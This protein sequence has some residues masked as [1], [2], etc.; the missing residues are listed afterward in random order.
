MI[1][2]IT[3]S[4]MLKLKSWYLQKGTCVTK[5]K[6]FKLMGPWMQKRLIW[7][8]G[9]KVGQSDLLSMQLKFEM[10]QHLLNVYTY[11][12]I[13]VSEYVEKSPE[14]LGPTTIFQTGVSKRGQFASHWYF[15]SLKM[16]PMPFVVGHTQ[17]YPSRYT[18]FP[19]ITTII[20]IKMH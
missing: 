17:W 12:H 2:K 11:F 7:P 6:K 19:H 18:T 5:V 9:C 1:P 14:N 16:D 10:S 15:I 8:T 4:Q 3:F 13:N 20:K